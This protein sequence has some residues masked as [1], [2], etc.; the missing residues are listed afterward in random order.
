VG[1]VV[2]FG[3]IPQK[4]AGVYTAGGMCNEIKGLGGVTKVNTHYFG[5]CSLFWEIERTNKVY[6]FLV[7]EVARLVIGLQRSPHWHS[8]N[9]LDLF[10]RSISQNATTTTI[11]L[12]ILLVVVDI[13]H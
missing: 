12:Y 7:R 9:L 1:P 4:T 3:F 2:I 11:Y 8:K 6:K 13:T 10:L 5:P